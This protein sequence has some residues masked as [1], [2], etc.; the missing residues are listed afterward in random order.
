[1]RHYQPFV[2]PRDE[3]IKRLMDQLR[4]ALD[5]FLQALAEEMGVFEVVA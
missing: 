5:K 3:E 2:D 1:M 4:A